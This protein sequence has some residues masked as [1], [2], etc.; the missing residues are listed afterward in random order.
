MSVICL[1][2]KTLKI[3]MANNVEPY[4]KKQISALHNLHFKEHKQLL[5]KLNI[6]KTILL[7]KN[8]FNE[9]VVYTN[10]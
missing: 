9:I 4:C 6:E 10:N 7:E 1:T 3:L 5:I 2:K 8:Y